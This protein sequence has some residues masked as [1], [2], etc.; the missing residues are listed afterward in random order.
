MHRKMHEGK[1]TCPLCMRVYSKV[2]NL[3]HHMRV[4]HHLTQ[5]EVHA[6]VP[7]LRK[8]SLRFSMTDDQLL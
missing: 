8:G 1:T 7:T 5:M 3:R 2:S 4:G 6:M